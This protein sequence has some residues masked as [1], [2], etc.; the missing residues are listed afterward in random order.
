MEGARDQLRVLLIEDSDSDVELM[1]RAL[2]GLGRPF[3]HARVASERALREILPAFA[4]DVIL[5]DFSM[6]GFSGRAALEIVV[7]VRP[8]TPFLFV[9]GTIGEE[10]AIDALQRGA[11]DYVLKDNLRRLAPAVER[12]LRN[13]SERQQRREMERALRDSEERFRSIVETSSDW[14]WE[15]LEDTTAVYTNGAI[16]H[17]LGY[18]PDELL[19]RPAIEHMLPQDRELVE[20]RLPHLVAAGEGWERW[21][22]RWR[23]RDGSVRVL[24]STA[25]VRVDADGKL[26]GFRGVDR[27]ITEI[28]EQEARIRHLARIHT[29]LGALGT[30]VLRAGSRGDLQRRACQVAVE[31]GGFMAACISLRDPDADTIRVVS[32]YGD[33]AVL[34]QVAPAEPIALSGASPYEQHPALR[35][36]REQRPVVVRDFPRSEEPPA[37]REQ[38]ARVGVAAQATIPIGSD[39][40]G[41]LVLY[42][43]EPQEFGEEEMALLERLAGE[44]D[45]GT[46]FIAK[47][48]RLEFLAYR[49]P[50]SEL[51]NR[52]AFQQRL[53]PLLKEAM[54]VVL[55]NIERFAAI[56]ESRGRAFGDALLKQA[57]H[58]VR[59]LSGASALVA[60]PDADNFALAY[61]ASGTV[62]IELERLEGLMDEFEKE[63]FEIDGEEIRLGIRAGLAISPDHGRNAET[64]ENNA[65]AALTEAKKRGLRVFGFN[66]E[67]RGR[68]ARRLALE[69]ELRDAI[70][71]G[72]FELYYQPEFGAAD[73]H[74]V[75]A[76][77]L[78]RWRHPE[79]GLISPAEFIPLLEESALI[80]PVGHWVMQEA[81]RAAIAWRAHRTGF[82][83]A[84]N[85]SAR[86]LRHAR[87]LDQVRALLQPHAGDQVLDIEVTESMLMDEIDSSIH[88]LDSLRD[89]GCRVAIDDFG[90]GYS[91]LN[92]LARLPVDTIKID[93]SFIGVLTQSPQTL[94]LVTNM[95]NLAHSLSLDVIAEG[96]EEE[97]QAHLLR[98]LRCDQ[99]QGF[100]LGRPMPAAEFET[101]LQGDEP[102]V[103]ERA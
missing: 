30:A 12:A 86:E 67:L 87:F 61:R 88:L 28:L 79:R 47:S 43:D 14:I 64:L 89:L 7:A 80:V 75:G 54:A 97:S 100:L 70:D 44:I 35:A 55:L 76:E 29:V 85:V 37:L 9:S 98:L 81:L 1:L 63:S 23:H 73:Q 11:V 8:D 74:L 42:S 94:A 36:Y 59:A 48:E 93:Q 82:R 2:Q 65:A 62:D 38:M 10:M 39:A 49:N 22:L 60:H 57:G 53:G 99:L 50:V 78:L 58:R 5:S 4:P 103:A 3:R 95:I 21:R 13:S 92:Y 51:P 33:A 41:L 6:P 102:A 25:T 26:L 20:A 19:G 90:T 16:A 72:Q 66:E 69:H 56:N 68:A 84:V 34:A 15:N 91:S 31:K 101:R 96:V 45:F 18:R 83:I 32:S 46:D 71:T 27:D 17:I 40:M 24:E 52:V 77:A